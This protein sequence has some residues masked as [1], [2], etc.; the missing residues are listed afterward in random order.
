ML[1]KDVVEVNLDLVLHA[2]VDP[3]SLVGN[4]AEN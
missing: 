3:R 1:I 4:P 2:D